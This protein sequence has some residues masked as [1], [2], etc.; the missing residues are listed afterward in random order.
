MW[1]WSAPPTP[2]PA[3]PSAPTASVLATTADVTD[4][5]PH[6]VL[7]GT[8]GG[9]A[10]AGDEGGGGGGEGA[11]PGGGLGGTG[12]GAGHGGPGGPGSPL[13][14]AARRLADDV[15]APAA[16]ATDQAPVVPA[17]HLRALADAGLCGLVGPPDAGGS[18]A[19]AS[20]VRQVYEALAGACGVTFFVWVQHHAPVRMLAASAN[21]AL[22]SRWLAPLCRGDVLGGVAFAYLRR[23]GPP[24]VVA[25]PVAGGWVVGGVAPFVTSWG[26]ARVVAVAARAGDD[27]VFFALDAE[28]EATAARVAASP[29]LGLAAM[30]ASAT[31]RLTFDGL[32]VPTADVIATTPFAAWS[33]RDRSATASPHPAA[34]GLAATAVRLLDERGRVSGQAA[35][36]SAADALGRE[37]AACRHRSWALADAGGAEDRRLADLVAA[38]AWSL[39]VALRSA[40]ALVAACGGGAM[41]TSHPAQRLVREAAFWSIQAQTL[42]VREATLARLTPG[43]SPDW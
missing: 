33:A 4:T 11:A 3:T 30:A 10:R 6:D 5:D 20:V 31:V 7:A 8:G 1:R 43:P 41:A 36:S 2:W 21:A 18:A 23:P 25:R 39:D 15:L 28:A 17:G 42:P 22:R 34:F 35:V 13:V 12:D 14:A 24:A 32:I 16:A 9:D 29:P 26:L 19:P 27:I 37:L 40:A 38:R